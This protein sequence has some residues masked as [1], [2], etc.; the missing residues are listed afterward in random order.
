LW[1]VTGIP[2]I[3][4]QEMSGIGSP[5]LIYS[6]LK[7]ALDMN[8][9]DR[10]NS[11]LEYIEDNLSGE[12]DYSAAAEKAQCSVSNFHRMFSFVV[13]FP[14]SEYIRRRRLSLA[15]ME[16]KRSDIKIIDL[17][18]KYGY[19]SPDS[20]TRAFQKLHG[21]APSMARKQEAQLKVYPRI[22]FQISIK[23]DVEMNY[24]IVEKE[25]VKVFG[26]SIAVGID[27]DPNEIL[28]KLWVDIQEDGTYQRICK[29]A[30]AKPYEDISLGGA[31]YDSEDPK[32]VK[33]N[34][35]IFTEYEDGMEI[36]QDLDSMTIPGGKWAVFTEGYDDVD[37]CSS[38]VQSLWRRLM[39]GWILSSEYHIAKGPQLEA[40]PLD[41]NVVEIW[42]PLL[43]K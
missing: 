27:E 29:A 33:Y 28:P 21:I 20:F 34:Y 1:G 9:F 30:G 2:Y 40:Y 25:Q 5:I 19:E 36:P 41:R 17:A 38:K 35:M 18:L 4:I 10:M 7:G 43:E 14:L 11:A 31:F 15:A 24:R 6:Q 26:K 42:I 37:E 8:W 22:S 3:K 12:I 23:G 16:L 32:S 13:D 39:S